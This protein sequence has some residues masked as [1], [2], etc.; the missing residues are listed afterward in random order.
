MI[1]FIFIPFFARSLTVLLIGEILQG[2]S[3]GVFVSL[4][5]L[6]LSEIESDRIESAND[7]DCICRRSLSVSRP[8]LAYFFR[9]L[10]LVHRWIHICRCLER[11]TSQYDRMGLQD[12]IRTSMDVAN[13][14]SG[15]HVFGSRIPLV[16][17]QKG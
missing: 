1:G 14:Y 9:E 16:L 3:W 5:V 11:T 17:C 13:P 15:W 7:D 2:L 6:S 4:P 10:V 12:P 8:P